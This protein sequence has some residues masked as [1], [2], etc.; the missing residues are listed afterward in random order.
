MKN[1]LYEIKRFAGTGQGR[2]RAKAFA[3]ALPEG[4]NP[5]VTMDASRRGAVS[6]VVRYRKVDA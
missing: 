4:S 2:V 5:T 1:P 3:A 6:W